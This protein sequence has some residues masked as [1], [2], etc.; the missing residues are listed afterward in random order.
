MSEAN[1]HFE[2]ATEETELSQTSLQ[3]FHSKSTL[4]PRT[5]ERLKYLLF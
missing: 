2:V 3:V 4:S 5:I 1:Y